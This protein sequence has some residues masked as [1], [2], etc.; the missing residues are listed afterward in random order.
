MATA[1]VLAALDAAGI[2]C[3]T[4]RCLNAL[5]GLQM[6]QGNAI[7]QLADLAQTHFGMVINRDVP[8]VDLNDQLDQLEGQVQTLETTVGE[9]EAMIGF[10]E[11]QLQAIDLALNNANDQLQFQQAQQ[12]ALHAPT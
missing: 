5:Y 7:A 8:I 4:A 6:Y 2:V 11:E 1:H 10:L 3:M 9:H 12:D